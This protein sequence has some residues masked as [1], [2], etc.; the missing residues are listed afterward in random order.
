MFINPH[1]YQCAGARIGSAD[2]HCSEGAAGG[3]VKCAGDRGHGSRVARERQGTSGEC[4]RV[5]QHRS[6]RLGDV[7]GGD[8]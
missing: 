6:G 8:Q 3:R 5:V 4:S 2:V 7:G 1:D